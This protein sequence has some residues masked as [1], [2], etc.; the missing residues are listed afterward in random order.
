MPAEKTTEATNSDVPNTD[1]S[2]TVD[3]PDE[4]AGPAVEAE[5]DSGGGSAEYSDGPEA[6]E[7]ES[8]PPEELKV[9]VSI[10][11]GRATIGVQ[12]P[13]SDPHIESFDDPDLSGLTQEVL[14]VT[15]RARS[16]W[17]DAPKH[18]AHQRP[19]PPARRRSR[20]KRGAT[21]ATTPDG[22]AAEQA[23]QQRL[24]LF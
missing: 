15:E 1:E 11:G 13:S 4:A 23:Q 9:V 22:D 3:A 2:T 5:E 14:A 21:Q 18:P 24:K 20:R 7:C 8:T 12:R 19:A 6:A 16:R 10:R 17:E